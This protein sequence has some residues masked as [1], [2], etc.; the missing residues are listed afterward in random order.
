MTIWKK[1]ISNV[2]KLFTKLEP[3]PHLSLT[4]NVLTHEKKI[5][6]CGITASSKFR[7][8][9][10]AFRINIKEY[11]RLKGNSL[12]QLAKISK[13]HY[14]Y[15]RETKMECKP[16]LLHELVHHYKSC[17]HMELTFFL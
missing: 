14:E 17:K 7:Q 1:I 5:F 8:T 12:E 2:V 15:I 16:S 6:S 13:I 4:K 11:D 10:I 9:L 3:D